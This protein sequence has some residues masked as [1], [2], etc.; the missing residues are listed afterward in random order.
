ML[1]L[2]ALRIAAAIPVIFVVATVVF[3]LLRFS[4]G[5][6]ATIMAGD[7][8]SPERIEQLR[9]ALGLDQPIYTQYSIW[10]EEM[11]KG[12][13]GVSIQSKQSVLTLVL[14]RLEP[15][16][17]LAVCS[18]VL[19]VVIAVPLGTIAAWNH[20]RWV[21]RAVMALSVA[22]FSM[23]TFVTGYLLI[24]AFAM[25]ADLL[26][27]QGYVSPFQ[28]LVGS[29]KHLVLPSLTLSCVLIAL[30]SRV[31]RSSVLDV[32]GENFIKTALAKGSS[33]ARILWRHALP[34]AAIPI[35]TVVGA[36]VALVISGVVVTES[37][38]NIPGLGRLTIDAILSRD[39]PV[40]QGLILLFAL[41]YVGI[42]LVVDVLYIVVDPRI[43][44]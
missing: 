17:V 11:A 13:L 32:L 14:D 6:P 15:T 40:V 9:A 26:P 20:N 22:G 42:N 3:A 19:T 21:D 44:Y 7:A 23:P 16:L 4:P 39:Y 34:N 28:D 10:L 30:I 5:D 31:T 24:L 33:G 43:R 2:I 41:F 12:N 36:A 37:V 27:V 29:I 35:I 8:A 18:I 1:I 38:F 25:W